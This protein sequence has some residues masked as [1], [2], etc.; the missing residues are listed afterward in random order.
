MTD[1]TNI[2]EALNT[3]LEAVDNTATELITAANGQRKE[4]IALYARM[5]ETN[6]DLAEFG[7]MVGE[8]G[9]ALL[10]VEELC[11][12]VATKANAAIESGADKTPDCDYEELV[13]F[14]AECGRAIVEG[15]EYERNA[16][17]WYTCEHCLNE[18]KEQAQM[19]I[20]DIK[21]TTHEEPAEA[22]AEETSAE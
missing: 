22:P 16:G 6:E 4:L 12:D 5:R 8:V 7:T 17:D 13:D 15:E 19:T 10:D 20:N 18:Y 21:E 1:F 2:R 11:E 14:C 9:G 3:L